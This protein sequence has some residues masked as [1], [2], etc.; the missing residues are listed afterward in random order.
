MTETDVIVGGG[1]SVIVAEPDLV[2]SCDEIAMT[3][4]CV[5]PD[6]IAGAV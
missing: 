4:T 5:V 3:E 6:T 2:E 1:V